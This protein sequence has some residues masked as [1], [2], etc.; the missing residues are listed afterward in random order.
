MEVVRFFG[1][2]E[3]GRVFEKIGARDRRNMSHVHFLF[4]T[5][6][7]RE[8]GCAVRIELVRGGAG[9]QAFNHSARV[10]D[11]AVAVDQDRAIKVYGVHNAVFSLPRRR[12]FH[13]I[14]MATGKDVL[15]HIWC[16]GV[17]LPLRFPSEDHEYAEVLPMSHQV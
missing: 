6:L 9:T 11:I 14:R 10:E 17:P 1:N 7:R 15:E 12:Y 2:C 13:D 4:K 8:I 3:Y 16:V 5:E